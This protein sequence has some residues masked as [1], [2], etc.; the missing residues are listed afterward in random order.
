MAVRHPGKTR[1]TL[2]TA[3][4]Q[5]LKACLPVLTVTGARPGP[6]AVIIAN[7][8]GRE[9]NGIA[10][11][12]RVFEALNPRT[13][14]GRV[15]FLPVMNPV[16]TRQR[17]QDYPTESPRY[18]PTGISQ[19]I[20]INRTWPSKRNPAA[21]PDTY[22]AA[23]TD[24]VWRTYL[25]HADVGIDLHGWSGTS[26]SLAWAEARH[27]EVVRA[28]G[29]PW[30]MLTQHSAA[31]MSED[32]AHSLNIPHVVCEL[33]PQNM[34]DPESVAFGE[35]GILNTLKFA[36]LLAG[37][38]QRPPVQYE[39]DEKH[40]E[41]VIRTPVEGLC[42]PC[43]AK[44]DWVKKGQ[45]VAHVLSLETLKKEFVYTAPQDS[46][47]FNIGGMAWGEDMLPSAIVSP[48]QLLGLLKVPSRILRNE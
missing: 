18:R 34:V 22:A 19:V 27:R 43:V 44:G 24:A 5:G 42:V 21:K 3:A 17:V 16:G 26:L 14:K 48:G 35:R 10:S 6:L 23:V 2:E 46:L 41:F 29:L 45:P 47:V 9:L 31:G 4:A 38:P 8:H 13:L 33:T 32:A 28:F 7:Q 30:H 37:Q 36:G 25:R 1:S 12:A 11:I 20:N 15:V 40:T 39:F